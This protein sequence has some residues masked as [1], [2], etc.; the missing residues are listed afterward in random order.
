VWKYFVICMKAFVVQTSPRDRVP[1]RP[2]SDE[3]RS[4]RSEVK[5]TAS[6]TVV[7]WEQ[8]KTRKSEPSSEATRKNAVSYS[9]HP[10]AGCGDWSCSLGHDAVRRHGRAA[11]RWDLGSIRSTVVQS[12]HRCIDPTHTLFNINQSS[13]QTKVHHGDNAQHGLQ[14]LLCRIKSRS[15]GSNSTNM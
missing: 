12:L 3:R 14:Q 7:R 6:F 8:G 2:H 13:A 9:R 15:K 4:P 1:L 11:Q 5:A 10:G